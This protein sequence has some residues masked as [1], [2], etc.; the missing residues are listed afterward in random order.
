MGV[1]PHD[2]DILPGAGKNRHTGNKLYAR[3]VDANK[4]AFVLADVRGKDQIVLNVYKKVQGRFLKKGKDQLYY[5]LDKDSALKK[6][7]KALSEN[8]K[9]MIENLMKTG[10]MKSRDPQRKK[11]STKSCI[12]NPRKQA[13]AA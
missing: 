13:K 9:V 5:I 2:N 4:E 7:K 10:K 12:K 8:N 3:L 1:T 6:I 11:L